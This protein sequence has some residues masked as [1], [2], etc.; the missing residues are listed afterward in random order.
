MRGLVLILVGA[1]LAACA[2]TS[3]RPVAAPA[4]AMIAQQNW[5]GAI[6]YYQ[7]A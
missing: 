5:L 4:E 1:L 6:R 2:E 3:L 7:T